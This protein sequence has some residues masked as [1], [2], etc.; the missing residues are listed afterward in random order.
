MSK[1]PKEYTDKDYENY[2]KLMLETNTLHSNNVPDSRYPKSNKGGKWKKIL[3]TIWDNRKEYEGSEVAVIPS[4]PN[5]LLERLNLLLASKKAG[6][7][8]V[9]NELVS[10]CEEI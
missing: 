5:A 2:V 10:I 9:G 3:K 8:N 7:M 4:N 1:E 6:H